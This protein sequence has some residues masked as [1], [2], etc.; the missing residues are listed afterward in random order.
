[1]GGGEK[2]VHALASL[3]N[4]QSQVQTGVGA[5]VMRHFG[6]GKLTDIQAKSQIKNLTNTDTT[7][8]AEKIADLIDGS[9][10]L[11]EGGREAVGFEAAEKAKA[12]LAKADYMKGDKALEQNNQMLSATYAKEVATL[13]A[14]NNGKALSDAQL[15][16]AGGKALKVV[17]DSGFISKDGDTVSGIQR[18]MA[19]G[20]GSAG[21]LTGLKGISMA[22][23]SSMIMTAGSSGARVAS[24]NAGSDVSAGNSS[25]INMDVAK[26]TKGDIGSVD[27]TTQY[28]GMTG[29]E[30]LIA[31]AAG[32]A[33]AGGIESWTKD[34]SGKGMI[35]RGVGEDKK[36]DKRFRS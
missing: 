2:G 33:I 23:G 7:L 17:Q 26:I 12:T 4:Q 22:D 20:A 30:L 5:R 10:A 14:A 19:F 13:R 15:A 3:A 35:K 8:G 36:Q 21:N 32:V 6:V 29:K 1:M 24:I 18:A 11:T 27:P 34:G 25:T 9:G 16:E 31:G 28:L